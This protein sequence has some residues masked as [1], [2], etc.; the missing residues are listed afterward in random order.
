M[1]FLLLYLH[2]CAFTANPKEKT[3][4]NNFASTSDNA[5][6]SSYMAT[7]P[8]DATIVNR[9]KSKFCRIKFVFC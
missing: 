2:H 3:V 5:D 8:S 9:I 4:N 1:F 6:Q 7:A